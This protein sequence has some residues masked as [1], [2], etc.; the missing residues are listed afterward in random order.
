MAISR[1]S[2]AAALAKLTDELGRMTLAVMADYRG[3]TVAEIER[4]RRQ[5]REQGVTLRVTKN[6]LLRLA[7]K[8]APGLGEIDSGL[9]RGPMAL[10]IGFEEEV[11]PAR[12][13]SIFA[14]EHQALAIVGAITPDGR[15]LSADEVKT[16]ALLPG[17][18][19][20][21]G[22]VVGTIAAPLA[23]FVGVM[24]ANVRGVPNIL[25]A[26]KDAKEPASG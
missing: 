1:Q 16:L 4:L 20:L 13:L 2:K 12:L 15:I 5:A 10:A 25:N 26:I 14:R 18:D 11:T 6:T 24:Q 7:A 21:L 19:Q 22:T 9:F 8:Q 17:R 3:L 23:D